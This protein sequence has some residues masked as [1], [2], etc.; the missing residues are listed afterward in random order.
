MKPQTDRVIDPLYT[1]KDVAD[2]FKVSRRT[3]YD[4]VATGKLRGKKTGSHRTAALR[5]TRKALDACLTDRTPTR[6]NGW[7]PRR[8]ASRTSR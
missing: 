4:W 6:G 7:K 3:V 8:R 1:V 5:F 2:F